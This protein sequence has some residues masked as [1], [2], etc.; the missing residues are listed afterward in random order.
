MTRRKLSYLYPKEKKVSFTL[1]A[2]KHIEYLKKYC[3]E[4]HEA[5]VNNFKKEDVGEVTLVHPMFY[6]LVDDPRRYRTL[7][8][9]ADV[10]IGFDV[11]DTDK[12]S[13]LSAY[14]SSL[15]D[16]VIVPSSFCREVYKKSGV[17]SNVIVLPHGVS[18]LWL[19]P[20][21][22]PRDPDLIKLSKFKGKKILFFLWHSGFRKGA[23]IVAEAF[24]RIVKEF[25][26][27]YLIVKMSGIIDPFVQY[28]YHIP[29]VIIFNKWFE[30]DDL[31]DLYDLCDI[32]VVPSRGGGFEQNALEGLVRKK[33]VVVSSWGSFN[34]Y[35]RS[36]I[37]IINR[38]NVKLFVGDPRANIIHCGFGVDP[39]PVDL[40]RKLKHVL[41]NFDYW[42]KRF[43][44]I[45]ESIRR[46]YTWNKI[47]HRLY[48]ILSKYV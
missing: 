34:D 3:L 31:I 1:I 41:L 39:D 8:R 14:V 20:K 19:R 35:C 36:C 37:K 11:C 10:L 4:I 25:K 33:I 43:E 9:Y 46:V 42:R 2:K 30:E 45:S 5:D 26:D 17:L 32:V 22:E 6:P 12:I 15:F 40:Y 16:L 38:K 13:P 21:R 44:D 28:M 18:S 24:S 23:D 48:M 27:V 29:N 7:M 47:C